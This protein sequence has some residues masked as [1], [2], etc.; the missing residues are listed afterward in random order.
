MHRPWQALFLLCLTPRIRSHPLTLVA[1]MVQSPHRLRVL[2]LHGSGGDAQSFQETMEHWNK[3]L[4]AR[5]DVSLDIRTIT[6]PVK[7]DE[8]G[9]YAWWR[10]PPGVR[11]YQATE[12]D[13]F[14][15]SK[16]L[17]LGTIQKAPEPFDL[18]VG[19]SQGSILLASL[20][21]LSLVPN[22]PRLGY[23]WNGVAWPNPFTEQLENLKFEESTSLPSI[24]LIVGE[25][26]RIN[27][28]EQAQRVEQAFRAANCDV[29]S[30]YHPG[31]HSVPV[32]SGATVDQILDYIVYKSKKSSL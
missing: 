25:K 17:V 32:Q 5:A 12:F 26:D 30:I 18:I 24:L 15:E 8:Q 21:A 19:H 6:A 10:L 2:A 4:Q 14:E 23:I 28:P 1:G 16:A 29:Q 7:N 22:H 3:A 11:S 9:G 27:A 13:R 31:G 20:L